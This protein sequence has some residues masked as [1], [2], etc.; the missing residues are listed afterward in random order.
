MSFTQTGSSITLTSAGAALS[1]IVAAWLCTELTRTRNETR[2]FPTSMHSP[3]DAPRDQSSQYV[4][5][6]SNADASYR[7]IVDRVPACVCVA[8]PQ[9]R[10]VYVNRVGI[11]ALGKPSEEIMGDKWQDFIHPDD[12]NEARTRW[13]HSIAARETV[14]IELRILQYD[15]V[16]RWQHIVAEPFFDEHGALAHWY[17]VGTEIEDAIGAKEA[18]RKSEREARELL[19][20][21][22]GRF[23]TRTEQDF[24]FVNRAI[25][26][27]TGTTLEAL[28]KF[29]FLH[30]VHP[31]DRERI[32]EGYLRSQATKGAHDATYRWAQAD[33]T[34]RWHYSRSVPYFNEDGT[35]Y[36]WY[37][38]HEVACRSCPHGNGGDHPCHRVNL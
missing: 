20:R 4:P 3:F 38:R 34:Y 24:D 25:L 12:A 7:T 11:S 29:G 35:V 30:F 27:E 31:D 16:Y 17:V 10:L 33:G 18:L 36:K 22:P 26:E 37:V 9:G 6:E 2:P 19:E 1:T 28:Q 14:D 21:L 5:S 32:R 13:K 15:N 8:D 23:A